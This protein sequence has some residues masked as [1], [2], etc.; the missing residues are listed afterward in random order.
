MASTKLAFST[1]ADLGIEVYRRTLYQPYWVHASKNSS[2]VIAG[3]TN[4]PTV[5][6]SVLVP[7]PTFLSSS[8]LVV[9]IMIALIAAD[10]V[11]AS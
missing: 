9:I 11:I 2:E 8:M 3:I 6:F 4:K 10:P 1:G 5:V 7:L